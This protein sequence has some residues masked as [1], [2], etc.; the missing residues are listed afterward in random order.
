MSAYPRKTRTLKGKK[1]IGIE[2]EK[3]YLRVDLG[4]SNVEMSGDIAGKRF[5]L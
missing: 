2:Q 5:F 4:L 3:G 1:A